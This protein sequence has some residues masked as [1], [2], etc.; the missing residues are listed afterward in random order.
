MTPQR[1][2]QIEQLYHAA[3]KLEPGQRAV[4]LQEGCAGDE[5]LRREVESLLAHEPQGESFIE[6]S[7]LEGAAQAMAE[8]RVQSLVGRQLGAYKILSLLGAGGM[9][10]VYRARDTRLDRTVAL[11]TLPGEVAADQERMRRF[12]RE[13]KAASALSHPN[14][15]HIYDIGD[16]E[17]VHFIAM[18]YI[19]GETLAQRIHAGKFPSPGAKTPP[20]PLGRGNQ[21]NIETLPSP[22]GRGAGG[23]GEQGRSLETVKILEISIQV[24]DA[25]DEAHTKGITHRDIKP[26]NI[27]LTPRGQVKVLDFGL[28]KVA[29]LEGA[30][31]S[32]DISTLVKTETGV[33]MGTV[34]YMSPE[35]VL[36]KEVDHR[37]D[38]FSLGVVLYEMTTGRLPFAGTSTSETMDRILHGQPEAIARFNYSVPGELERIIRK[39]LE[40]DRERRY[41]SARELLIDLKSLKRDSDAASVAGHELKTLTRAALKDARLPVFRFRWLSV[42][43][44]G[45]A[46]LSI[47][48]IGSAVWFYF[49]RSQTIPPMKVVRLTSFPGSETEPALSPDGK[50]VAFVWD[51]EKGD[52][53]DIYAMFVDSG[54]PVRLTTDPGQDFSPTWSPDGRFIAFQRQLKEKSGIYLI[55]GPYREGPERRLAEVESPPIVGFNRYLD[56]S[57]D[58]KY[59]AVPDRSPYNHYGGL[60]LL[61][62]ENGEKKQ[63]S[64]STSNLGD[65]D[66]AFS[67]DGQILAFSRSVGD[68]SGTDIYSV[69]FQ[70]GEAKRLTSDQRSSQG[71]WGADGREIIFHGP[72]GL[73]RISIDGGKAAPLAVGGQFGF[74]PSVSRVGNRLVYSEQIYDTD[75]WQI[76]LPQPGVKEASATRLIFSSQR[77]E[78]PQFSPDGKRIVFASTRSGSMEIWICDSDGRNPLQL[79]SFGGPYTTGTPRW[80]PDGKLIAFDSR[81]NGPSDIFVISPE[82]GSPRRLTKE[83][84]EDVIP[85]WSRDGRSIYFCSD[86]SGNGNLQ[87]WK[88]PAEGGPATQVTQNGGFEAFESFDRKWL[89]YSK[90]DP[91]DEIWRIPIA[92]GPES[93]F[94]NLKGVERRYWAVADKGIYFLAT[95][96]S[97]S[98]VKFID[99]ATRRATRIMTLERKLVRNL[100]RGLAL[101][102]D[103]RSLLCTLVERESSDL[104]LVENFR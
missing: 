22:L 58:G 83:L 90:W 48:I 72:G 95:E 56:W 85:S 10:E 78:T 18:E 36:G 93:L 70:G 7:A 29:R 37:T 42:R 53:A 57:P 45:V 32:S 38:I 9:G 73:Y 21:K 86:R 102:P 104:V 6:A 74:F 54:K 12:T 46:V 5:D 65:R 101:S 16:F 81:P 17:G 103:G 30:A 23:E 77:E 62:V 76:N 63:I 64:S 75:I 2:K 4:F 34:Q 96:G 28:A 84:S 43:S 80:A 88:M 67:Q 1:W 20:S 39:C 47:L 79:T 24:A 100:S 97:E 33:V 31:G 50:M 51:G 40:K 13:A 87:I 92:G 69:P 60:M 41:Q 8:K 49:F 94:L 99:F 14:V 11:K 44:V 68:F 59:L 19:E 27:M 3:L 61:S 15:A 82:G 52:N 35:Q 66:P 25:L 98:V 89:F 55:P 91:S 26:G 71:V